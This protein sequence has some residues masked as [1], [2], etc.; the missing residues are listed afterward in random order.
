MDVGIYP[1]TLTLTRGTSAA[2][3]RKAALWPWQVASSRS[4][5]GFQMPTRGSKPA[6]AESSSAQ[7]S[8]LFAIG[9]PWSSDE[10][11]AIIRSFVAARSS[12]AFDKG[13][14]DR[15]CRAIHRA[16]MCAVIARHPRAGR[17]G[18]L[19]DALRRGRFTEAQMSLAKRL[20]AE[21]GA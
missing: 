10:A 15:I 19:T 9:P 18:T 12:H 21:V 14:A 11:K 3:R 1:A 17:F 2:T 16:W 5:G 13:Q 8:A 4:Y 7:S 6:M 20:V